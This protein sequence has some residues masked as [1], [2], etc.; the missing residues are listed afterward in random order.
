[1][2]QRYAHLSQGHLKIGIQLLDTG[3]GTMLGTS[4]K[5]GSAAPQKLRF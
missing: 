5:P 3:L 4:T 2:T 1:M